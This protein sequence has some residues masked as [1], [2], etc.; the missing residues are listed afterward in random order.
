[1]FYFADQAKGKLVLVASPVLQY[2]SSMMN[3]FGLKP[4]DIESSALIERVYAAVKRQLL[5][6]FMKTHELDASAGSDSKSRSRLGSLKDAEDEFVDNSSGDDNGYELELEQDKD[7]EANAHQPNMSNP[8]AGNARRE[9]LNVEN[10]RVSDT[11][12]QGTSNDRTQA[13]SSFSTSGS[14]TY[15]STAGRS[16]NRPSV[17]PQM[18]TQAQQEAQAK[19]RAERKREREEKAFQDEQTRL[20][21]ERKE[22]AEAAQRDLVAKKAAT[23]AAKRNRVTQGELQEREEQAAQEEQAKKTAAETARRS[24]ATGA[25][26]SQSA[27]VQNSGSNELMERLLKELVTRRQPEPSPMESQPW[28]QLIEIQKQQLLSQQEQLDLQQVQLTQLQ[29]KPEPQFS[30]QFANIMGQ[31]CSAD[32][33]FQ[34]ARLARQQNDS[35]VQLAELKAQRQQGAFS[36]TTTLVSWYL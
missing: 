20:E 35:A 17:A 9:V 21:Q 22:R 15:V 4:H 31:F 2:S 13:G 19:R 34:A 10:Q 25:S 28:Q 14:S 30:D 29:K 18:Y 24:R 7:V 16:S 11:S 23:E 32:N 12:N 27:T 6:Q 1:M 36:Q 33:I 5:A 8:G 26:S 3:C